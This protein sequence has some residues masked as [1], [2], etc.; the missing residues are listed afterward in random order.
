[1][2]DPLLNLHLGNPMFMEI[3]VI[4]K[5][6]NIPNQF[7]FFSSPYIHYQNYTSAANHSLRSTPS[8]PAITPSSLIT[9]T[10]RVRHGLFVIAEI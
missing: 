1:M 6:K 10:D 8:T 2:Y 3:E 4:R 5:D 7:S 9:G